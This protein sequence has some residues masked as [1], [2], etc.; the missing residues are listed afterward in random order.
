MGLNTNY[1]EQEAAFPGMKVDLSPDTVDSY[2]QG[3]A[4]AG[5]PFGVMAKQSTAATATGTP[6]LA[7]KLTATNN[8]LAG[9]VLHSHDYDAATE[10]DDDGYVVPK[11]PLSVLVKGRVWV[12]CEMAVVPSDPVYTRAVATGDEIAGSFRNAADGGD[13]LR[14]LGARFLKPSVT[15]ADGTIIAPLEF[16]LTS[17]AAAAI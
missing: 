9:I 8:K 14:I 7:A 6:P 13:E 11:Q 3:E 1:A 2:L 12:R 5:M 10:L 16:D 17:H 15:L 4:S